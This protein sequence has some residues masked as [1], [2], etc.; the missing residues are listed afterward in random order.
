MPRLS[1]YK[2]YK[3]NDYK[4]MDW[5]I[6]EQFDIGG[7]AIHVHKYLGPKIQHGT[8]DPSEP[9]LLTEVSFKVKV[10]W[11][12]VSLL[13]NSALLEILSPNPELEIIFTPSKKYSNDRGPD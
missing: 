1:L 11:Q 7:T 2:P 12:A 13:K 3:S 10:D 9:N 6:R 8:D 4:F 5:N